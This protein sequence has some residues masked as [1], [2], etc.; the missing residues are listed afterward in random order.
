MPQEDYLVVQRINRYW[1]SAGVVLLCALVSTAWLPMRRAPRPFPFHLAMLAFG[2][3]LVTLVTFFI[4]V[5]LVNKKTANWTR[6]PA[7]FERLRAL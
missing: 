4:W 6:A 2:L 1:P 5:F 7:D 3:L